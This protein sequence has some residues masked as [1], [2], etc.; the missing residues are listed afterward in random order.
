MIYE[1]KKVVSISKPITEYKK[2]Y[3]IC[4]SSNQFW[5]VYDETNSYDKA[6]QIIKELERDENECILI[7]NIRNKGIK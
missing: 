2:D 7:W 3:I 6:K 1:N 4:V 5:I